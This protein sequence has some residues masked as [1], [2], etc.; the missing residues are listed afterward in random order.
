MHKLSVNYIIQFHISKCWESAP[1][2]FLLRAWL[3]SFPK[4]ERTENFV[5][6]SAPSNYLDQSDPNYDTNVEDLESLISDFRL[7]MHRFPPI[8]TLLERRRFGL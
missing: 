1:L 5:A 6:L 2:F 4:I 3:A 7:E 8:L